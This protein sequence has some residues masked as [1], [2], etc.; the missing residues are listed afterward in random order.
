MSVTVTFSVAT[1]A[2]LNA[3]IAAINVGGSD[4]AT[5]TAY[6]I[7]LTADLTLTSN[8]SAINLAAG[9]TLSIQGSNADNDLLT[10]QL[11]G[12]GTY[13]GFVVNAGSV[14]LSNMS[15]TG[16]TA[17]SG[18]GGSPG[19][20][21]ALYVGANA[22]VV[23]SSVAFN[24]DTASGG[25]PAGGAIFVAQGGTLDVSGGSIAGGGNA[26]GNG[27]FIQGNDSITLTNT[28]VTGVIA[29]QTGSN[30]GSGAGSV[31]V[32]GAVTFSAANQYTGGT[33]IDG[34]LSLMAAGAA[35]TGAI[36]FAA[37]SGETLII[38]AG[39]APANLI[40]GFVPNVATG[41]VNADTIDLVGIGS[42][43]GYALSATNQLTVS[44]NQGAV[45]LNLD[46][47]QNY[48]ADA[49][50]LA[51]D[52]GSGAAA[53]T[54]VTVVQ[55]TFLVASEADLNA[56]LASIDVSGKWAAPNVAYTI[57]LTASFSLSTDLNAINLGSGDTLTIDGAG[58]TI[59]GAGKYRGFFDY[60]GSLTLQNLTIKNAAATGGT[61]GAGATPGGGGAGLG[62][63]LFVASS[64]A[65]TL[66]NVT[67][68]NDQAV[69]GAAGSNGGTGV[70]GG[71]GLG[72][73][74]GAGGAGINGARNGGGGGIGLLATGGSATGT[75]NGEAGIVIGAAA[76]NSGTGNHPAGGAGGAFGGGGGAAGTI[77]TSGSG[78]GAI[79]HYTPGIAGNG[80]VGGSFG[81]GASGNEAAGL[82]GGGANSAGGW[83]GG[84]SGVSAGGLGG[85]AGVASGA[86]GGLGAGGD[87]FVQQGGSLTIAGG[88]L[89]GGTVAG[90][91]GSGGGGSGAAFGDGI[92]VQG[93]DTLTFAPASGQ[94]LSIGDVIADGAG[95]G[96]TGAAG[97]T[98]N[99]AGTVV[100]SA[101]N[102]YTG[103]T[104]LKA[105]TLSLQMPGA[106]GSGAIT[107]AYGAA[108]TLVIGAG[109]VPANI[110]SGFL[111]G[112]VIDLQGIGTATSAVLGTGDIL[113]ISG[114]TS[115]VQLALDPAQNFTGESFVT[116]SDG[117]GGTLVTATDIANDFPPSISGTGTVTG[118]DHTSLSPLAGVTV[119]DL[120]P[121]QTEAVTLTL[122]SPL[123]GTLSNLS[124]GTYDAVHGVYTVTGN[125]AA[126][127]AALDALVFTPTMN[128]VA[129]G[130]N[131]AT[132]F[133]LS[134]TDGLM[135]STA[136]AT[137]VNITA[138]NDPPVISGVGGALVEG[139]WNVP[140][141][142][143]ASGAITDPDVGATETVTFRL[144]DSSQ[145]PGGATDGNGVLSLSLPGFTLTHTGVGTYSLS[146]GS[147]ADVS[148]AIE[149]LQFTAVPN[150]A[151]PGY[152]IT[153]VNM[154]VSDGIAPPVTSEVEVLT[155][156]P[157]FSGVTPNQTVVDGTAISPFSSVAITDSAG[158]SIQG[159]TITLF[160]SSS[161]YL[162]PTDANGTLSGANLVKTGVGT[163]TLTPGSTESVTA[164]LDALIFT[165]TVSGSTT[166]TYFNLSA[167]DGATTA[168]NQD[169]SVI[170]VPPPI[171]LVASI[172]ASPNTGD[173][174]A[175]NIITLT[176]TMSNSV[177]VTGTPT[178]ALND[179]GTAVYHSGSG[180][181]VLT[182]TY[183]VGNG[184]NVS[185]LAVTGNNLNGSNVAIRDSSGNQADLSGA[186]VTF[187]GLAIGAM[188]TSISANPSA[189]DLG[190]G[191]KV[192]F[193]VVMS[194]A[195]EVSGGTPYLSLNDGGRATYTSGSGT[196]LLT[197][198]YTA[199]ALGSGQNAA[200][201]AVTAFNPNGARV[202]DSNV[203]ADTA[204]LSGVAGFAGGPQIDTIAPT[205][206]SVAA[207]GAGI[208]NGNGDLD[209]GNTVTLTVDF[210]ENVTV[211]GTPYLSLN[212]G[213]KATYTSGSST[214]AL[215]FTYVVASGQNTAD[216]AVTGLST[217]GGSIRDGA[218]NNAVVTGAVTNPPGILK[219][220]T[221]AP[222]VTKVLVSPTS[223]EV[224]TGNAIRITLDTSEAVTVGGA[225][226]LLLN[227]GGTASYDAVHST[228]TA[229]AFNYTVL[230]GQA[231]T[232]LVVSGIQLSSTS[233]IADLAGNNANLSGAGANLGLHINTSSTGPAG[234]SGG[235]FTI[236]GNTELE[237]FGASR[238]NVTFAPGDTG[239][240]RLDA[241]SQFNGTV[242]GLALGNYLDLAGIAFGGS[243]TLGYTPNGNNTGGTLKAT[244]GSHIAN[245]ALLGQYTASSFIMAS[246]GHGGTLISDPPVTQQQI[247]SQPHT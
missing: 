223:G 90:G 194:E 185:A 129:P 218:G 40:D 105:G 59:D 235:N 95:S 69:G 136:A 56:A 13:R 167:F 81:G 58:N 88:S 210:S 150:P 144:A 101:T 96:I 113:T 5:N 196:K 176:L 130:Q 94:T 57:T 75:T 159:M 24:G 93:T 180:S 14:S 215:T 73:A 28:T 147:P 143:F 100:L 102:T 238:A 217:N 231:T 66:S 89:T 98:L 128:Q 125:A 230:T 122:S 197:F 46:P 170:A 63:G 107:F 199:G 121:G 47:T 18:T 30:L 131:V 182:F 243:T 141:N 188:V 120:N 151:V 10:A 78:R 21:G 68:I 198:T 51:A 229:L 219:I 240:L 60:A 162:N 239:T 117:N 233:S 65:A 124:G 137:T 208:T 166:K 207:S 54:A 191:K 140:L 11:D 227:D 99:G 146:A 138:L 7:I 84:G 44:G 85:G 205:V 6:Q 190:A 77:A 204:N 15:L 189:G 152:T 164:E 172:V 232:D 67:F 246:D 148:K 92:F 155:G 16:M 187:P 91:A 49:F 237:L 126:V 32:Q 50:V 149:A 168:D 156:L 8:I 225:P 62:G 145:G 86:G 4:S 186:D 70:G 242:A 26:A 171:P 206:S 161:N 212:D 116:A 37:P 184:Q 211:T 53:G 42:P 45:T 135:F 39:G 108:A 25:T 35:G 61:G 213:G 72:G 110:V 173:K 36:S 165:P 177:T 74:G 2:D 133:N 106:A 38:G 134:A 132:V 82:G 76:G 1:E 118:N 247:L 220:D 226:I 104:T 23:T 29:D 200:A 222:T 112:D 183:A 244:D 33:Q 163:Y 119:S 20:G 234:P 178:L 179:G 71:G 12:D 160:D 193:S 34:S 224:V 153:Y 181:N 203:T 80:G 241:S 97:V 3:A 64:G 22:S 31:V 216:L 195:V 139:Y 192:V 87:V 79:T 142:P 83:G 43:T 228:A 52:S 245:I 175:G 103:G 169:T 115:T 111:P 201:L 55:S 48:A 9:D 236:S 17:P 158:L 109:D 19:G 154:S 157:I 209:A 202:Y 41:H 123:N 127:T 221:K 214:S 27:I 114:G 174:N